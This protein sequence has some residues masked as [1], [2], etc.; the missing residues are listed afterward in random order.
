MNGLQRFERALVMDGELFGMGNML[1][2]LL[3]IGT[4]A[5]PILVKS[6]GDEQYAGC[7]GSPA[8]SHVTIWLGVSPHPPSPIHPIPHISLLF[9]STYQI[10]FRCPKNAQSSVVQSAEACTRWT[11]SDQLRILM[12]TTHTDMMPTDTT[13]TTD[14]WRQRHSLIS[15][16]LSTARW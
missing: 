1:M 3:G 9:Q 2:D 4:L 15:L 8:D 14:T 7:T 10:A 6:F 16:S 11:M 13:H 12:P 5:D